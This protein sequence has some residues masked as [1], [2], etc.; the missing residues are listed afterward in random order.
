MCVCVYVYLCVC[1]SVCVCVCL[2]VCGYAVLIL[3]AGITDPH[4]AAISGQE[5][6]G[7][8]FGECG[9]CR[10]VR[11]GERTKWTVHEVVY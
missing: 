1:M 9:K 6:A 5:Q 3:P 7:V 11:G 10:V 4:L 2:C 8:V